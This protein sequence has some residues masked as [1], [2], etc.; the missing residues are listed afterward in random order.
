MMSDTKRSECSRAAG[1]FLAG[2]GIH[3]SVS[4]L[5]SRRAAGGFLARLDGHDANIPGGRAAGGFPAGRGI[6]I[7]LSHR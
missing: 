3:I 7:S 6:H 2:R 4:T 5:D 1:G